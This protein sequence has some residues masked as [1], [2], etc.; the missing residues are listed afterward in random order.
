[1]V[2]GSHAHSWL[3]TRA[4]EDFPAGLPCRKQL[5]HTSASPRLKSARLE[6]STLQSQA[7]EPSSEGAPPVTLA[8][9]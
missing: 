5:T 2:G 8:T 6:P 9:G 1:M 3:F 7:P 4:Q